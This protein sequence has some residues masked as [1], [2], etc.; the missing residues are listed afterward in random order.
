MGCKTWTIELD[1]KRHTIDL[2]HGFW[3]GR[4]I[5]RIDGNLIHDSRKFLDT[6]SEHRFDVDGHACI[7]KIRNSP[8]HYDYEL[9]IDGKMV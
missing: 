9:F 5:V 6:G 1:G 4:R 7:L 3:S 8:F 2:V